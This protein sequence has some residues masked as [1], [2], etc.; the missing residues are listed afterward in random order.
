MRQ[1]GIANGDVVAIL[2]HNHPVYVRLIIVLWELGAIPYRY[3]ERAKHYAYLGQIAEAEADLAT[4]K[5]LGNIL[6]AEDRAFFT[7]MGVRLP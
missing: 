1:W 2:S 5:R 6:S 7:E 4:T 3:V